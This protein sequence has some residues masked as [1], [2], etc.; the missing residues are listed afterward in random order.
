MNKQLGQSVKPITPPHQT[1][2]REDTRTTESAAQRNN[3]H[4]HHLNNLIHYFMKT[5]V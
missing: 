2:Q 5:I 3:F 1:E 4:D